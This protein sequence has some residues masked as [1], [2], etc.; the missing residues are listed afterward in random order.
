[1]DIAMN[2]YQTLT[3]NQQVLR[4]KDAEVRK[5]LSKDNETRY[6]SHMVA[7]SKILLRTALRT[8]KGHEARGKFPT[9]SRPAA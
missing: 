7:R 9:I 3:F 1:M 4:T 8:G 5:A 6:L 2:K